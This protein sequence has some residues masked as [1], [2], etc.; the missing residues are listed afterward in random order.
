M[1]SRPMQSLRNASERS[2]IHLTGRFSRIEAC[3]AQKYSG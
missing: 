1:L 3:A 2:E